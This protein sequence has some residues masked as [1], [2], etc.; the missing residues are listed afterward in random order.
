MKTL[1]FFTLLFS[2]I[3]ISS[4]NPP[5][6]IV[7]VKLAED[8]FQ[9]PKSYLSPN[10]GYRNALIANGMIEIAMFLPD[11]SGYKEDRNLPTVGKYNKNQVTAFWTS[12]GTGG[13]YDA[14]KRL[15]NGLEY[16]LVER[17]NN[18][19]FIGLTAYRHILD[20]GMSYIGKNSSGHQVEIDCS[21]K[22]INSIC[23]IQYLNSTRNI[24]V[25]I[26]FDKKHLK[27]WKAIDDKLA[28]FIQDWQVGKS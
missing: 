2:A 6:N 5:N 12:Q 25:F 23:K 27:D 20:K 11:F 18:D 3:A 19:D 16:G 15:D 22:I 17:S 10:E 1:I 24:G 21:N 13:S 7:Q 14:Q 4:E 9:I 28:S 8:T 26:S